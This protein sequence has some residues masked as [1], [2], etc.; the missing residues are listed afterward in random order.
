MV[1]EARRVREQLD[2]LLAE[3]PPATTDPATFWGAQFD[4]GLAWVWFPEGQG[5]LGAS[6]GLQDLVKQVLDDAGA[7]DNFPFNGIGIG[8]AG[9][10]LQAFGSDDHRR[11]LLRRL[12]TCEDVWCQ[13]FS[14]PGAGSDVAAL[15]TSAVRDG[16][17]WVVNGQK[18][19]T[20]L[21]HMARWGLLLARTDPQ[22]PKHKGLTYF[23]VDMHAPGVDVRPLRQ[24]TGD[25]EFNEVYFTDARIPDRDRLGEVGDGWRVAIATLMNERN[26]ISALGATPR[27]AG[28]IG[29]AVQLWQASGDRDE[30]TRD[31]VASLWVESEVVRLTAVRAQQSAQAGIPGPEQSTGKLAATE[32]L[33]RV[34]DLCVDLLGFEGLLVGDYEMTRPR[35]IN[36]VGDDVVKGFLRSRAN[37]IEGGTSE[38]MRNILGERVL[39]LPGDVRVDKDLPWSQ[40]PRS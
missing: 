19:W 37:T 27:G 36:E 1:D 39:G 22:A 21:A 13:L 35:S 17:E 31:R 4:R 28:P 8:M 24:L 20:T 40:V 9:P 2:R 14:E 7:P 32:N 3:H 23:V 38:I 26:A 10:V 15:G 16:D 33:G 6:P 18:V 12:W 11:Q 29:T 25:A 5:G 30:A 34:H